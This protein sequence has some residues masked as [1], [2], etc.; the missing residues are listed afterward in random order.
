MLEEALS[1]SLERHSV[2]RGQLIRDAAETIQKA[3]LITPTDANSW[4]VQANILLTQGQR[5]AAET[6]IR[7]CISLD[8]KMA[9]AQNLLAVILI[10]SDRKAE[11]ITAFKQAIELDPTTSSACLNLGQLYQDAGDLAGALSMFKKVVEVRPDNWRAWSKIVQCCETLGD[12]PGRDKARETI[13]GLFNSGDV[14]S[15]MYCRAQFDV[16]SKKVMAFEHFKPKGGIAVHYQFFVLDA[17]GQ[18]F[19]MYTLA[20]LEVDTSLARTTGTLKA[21]EHMFSID[22]YD[23]DKTQTLVM[24]VPQAGSPAFDKT[25]ELVLADLRKVAPKAGKGSAKRN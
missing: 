11:A 7:K 20:E 22:R 14:N 18:P 12:L 8:P 21:D 19:C 16:D 2:R 25:C 10:E 24:M 9:K 17:K 15:K 13:F 1:L 3:T 5:E 4:F 6:A 23:P